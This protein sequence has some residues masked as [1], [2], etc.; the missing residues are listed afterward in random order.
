MFPGICLQ[1]N[2][3]PYDSPAAAGRV[4]YTSLDENPTTVDPH[5]VSDV[6]SQYIAS[7]I[8]DTAYEF[9]Y[10]KRPFEIVPS[11]ARALPQRGWRQD[12]PG[13]AGQR[14]YA[15][16]FALRPGL[17]FN[18]DPCFEDGRGREIKIDDLIVAF[19]R[20][21]DDR[22]EPFGKTFLID[23]LIGFREYHEQFMAAV[24]SVEAGAPPGRIAT[25][26]A[27]PIAGVHRVDDYTIELAY[28][29][30]YPQSL[31]FLT[32]VTSSPVPAECL[33][34]YSGG[35][36]GTYDRKAVASGPFYLKEWRD[37]YRLILAKNPNYRKDDVYPATG[38][39]GDAGQGL[40]EAAGAT[41]PVL[42]EVRLRIIKRGPP[43]W[44]LF[45][46]G[47]LDLYRNRLDLQER[48]MQSPRLLANYNERGVR[49]SR[50]VELSVFGWT[51][52]LEDPLFKN[53][54]ALR[55]AISLVIDREEFIQLFL[56]GRAIPA[57]G[58]VPP[59]LE[60]Y[61]SKFRGPY[62]RYDLDA[63]RRL[64]VEAGYPGGKDPATGRA[65]EIRL[66]DRAAQGRA[67]IY[68][69]YIDQFAKIG[70][71]LVVDEMDFPS[72]I[73]KMHAKDFQ[74]IHWGWGADYPD[75]E[76]FLQLLYGPNS[77]STYNDGSYRNPAYDE[78]YRKISGM[79]PGPERAA[80]IRSMLEILAA[81]LPKTFLFHRESH[82]FTQAWTAPLK[83]SPM[84]YREMKYWNVD[85]VARA[86]K[87]E[88]WNRV[89]W[90]GYVLLF[91][92]LAGLVG[93]IFFSWRQFRARAATRLEKS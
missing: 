32:N 40:L 5:R 90:R 64:L 8:H 66:F 15:L 91:G 30:P 52:N 85:P 59:G 86:A 60:G 44:A 78:L 76:N 93:L 31:F 36:R 73:S 25:A 35:E 84:D 14:V 27:E 6:D 56:P 67:A 62:S 81:D 45:E 34:Y 80:L 63:A 71:R 47:Y 19:R 9:H 54:A 61:D 16:R 20:A 46:Q 38:A 13:L 7:N 75:P 41:L 12:F 4:F 53:N 74:L 11:M 18:D 77:E 48:L 33:A 57:H 69:Y 65:L 37:H 24:D 17:R 22:I 26:L 49:K 50:E 55:R 21:A 51:F 89:G 58:P 72:L 3:N 88:S 10:L 87:I 29:A 42:D 92:L 68:R 23:K 2:N 39:V 1:C 70:L 83:P 43:R 28:F 82:Y 79:S